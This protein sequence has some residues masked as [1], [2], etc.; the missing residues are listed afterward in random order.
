VASECTFFD[1]VDRVASVAIVALILS[2][3]VAA[4]GALGI[5]L[6]KR[7]LGLARQFQRPGGLYAAAILRIVLGVSLFFSAPTSRSPEV[8]GIIGIIIFVS[9]LI[10][11]LFGLKRFGRLLDWWSTRGP[12]FMRVW[13]G[14]A[15]AIGLFLAYSVAP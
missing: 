8:V 11:P 15:L 13:A 7:L 10:T 3:F 5:I 12:V 9:G 1:P 14:I 2:L 6:P 4:L